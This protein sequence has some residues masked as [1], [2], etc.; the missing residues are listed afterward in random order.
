MGARWE[1]SELARWRVHVPRADWPRKTLL[2]AAIL[3]SDR[4]RFKGDYAI[5][6][7]KSRAGACPSPSPSAT[8]QLAVRRG[9]SW[10][11]FS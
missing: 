6:A 4:K 1:A 10:A 11:G 2:C 8:D 9:Q 5:F 7:A 3:A